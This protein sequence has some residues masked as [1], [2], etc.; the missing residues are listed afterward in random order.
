M[1]SAPSICVCLSVGRTFWQIF[2]DMHYQIWE[3]W[4][5]NESKIVSTGIDTH[6]FLKFNCFLPG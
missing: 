4:E 2:S 1:E 3:I 6:A 5:P